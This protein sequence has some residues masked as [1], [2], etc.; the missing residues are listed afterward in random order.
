MAIEFLGHKEALLDFL[1]PPIEAAAGGPCRVADLF[2]GTGAVSAGLKARGHDV[3]ANDQLTV[4]ATF[5]EATLLNDAEPGF[6]GVLGDLADGVGGPGPR[7]IAG[8]L[9]DRR[10]AYDRVL[11]Y[12]AALPPAEG[13]VWRSYSPASARTETWERRYF[14]E[15]NAGRIDAVRAQIALWEPRLTRGERALLLADLVRA[16]N[17]VSNIAGTYGCYLKQWKAR[18]R[19]PLALSPSRFVAGRGTHAVRCADAAQVAAELD[20][21][22][23]YADPPYTKRQYSAYYHLP[24]TIVRADAPPLEGSTGLRP[25]QETASAW[26]Y[27]R[28]AADALAALVDAARADWFFLSYNED[29]QIPHD[30]V[31]AILAARGEVQVFER[32]YRRYKSA[33]RPHRG[34]A[35][36][37]RLYRLR[38]RRP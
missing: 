12:L 28:H 29:G 1:L 8:P 25:W 16:A 20:V 4:C 32:E 14:T 5:A 10:T 19:E 3:V 7:G 37:E 15:D 24:E 23:I 22:V 27:R 18:A 9:F 38:R 11:A 31:L 36:T 21:D 26:C 30:R 2:C 17:A 35:V 34:N 33:D 6:A 13:F